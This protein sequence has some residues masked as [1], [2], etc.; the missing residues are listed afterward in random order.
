MFTVYVLYAPKFDKIYIGY[1][2]DFK[3]RILF[4][5]KKAKKG[6]TIRYRPWVVAHTEEF[7]SKKQA[8]KREKQLKSA[9]GRRYIWN[10]LIPKIL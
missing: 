3:T 1:S 5:N 4:H 2:S 7:S 10:E 8:I 6:W 9:Q